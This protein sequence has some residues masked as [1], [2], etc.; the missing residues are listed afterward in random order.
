MRRRLFEL[1]QEASKLYAEL[2]TLQANE[3]L[4]GTYLV[5]AAGPFE[6]V[7]P[8]T[9]V[10]EVVR[11]VEYTPLPAT[12]PHVLGTFLYRG[13][14]VVAIDLARYLGAVAHEP[15]LDAHVAVLASSRPMALVIDRVHTL[16]ETP[17]A[18]AADSAPE[19]WQKSKLVVGLCAFEGRTLPIIS[20]NSLIASLE[21][22][23]S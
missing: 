6:V 13:T 15:K 10:C 2:G 1:E 14:A 12:P 20:L 3:P 18:A 16:L 9:A 8:A 11:L 4:P 22:T 17:T 19:Q 23:A 5:V 21:E 7:V